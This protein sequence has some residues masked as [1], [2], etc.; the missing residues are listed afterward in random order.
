MASPSADELFK[1]YLFII[2]Q[3]EGTIYDSAL[4]QSPLITEEE[5]NSIRKLADD[6]EDTYGVD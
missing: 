4:V 3:E 6:A 5:L 2:I 1:K